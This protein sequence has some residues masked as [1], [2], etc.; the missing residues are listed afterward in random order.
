M[1]DDWRVM[2]D[3]WC[4]TDDAWEVMMDVCC[5]MFDDGWLMNVGWLYYIGVW[6][7]FIDDEW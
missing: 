1:I 7:L 4:L 6:W 5:L 2:I 3:G